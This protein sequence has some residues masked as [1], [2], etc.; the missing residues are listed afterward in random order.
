[1]WSLVAIV[2]FLNGD[3]KHYVLHDGMTWEQCQEDKAALD[4]MPNE[5]LVCE[6]SI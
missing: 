2:V 3:V 6:G 1:M 4:P 5:T